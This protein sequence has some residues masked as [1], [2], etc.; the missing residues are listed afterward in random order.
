M[1][2]RRLSLRP[3]AAILATLTALGLTLPARA[4]APPADFIA[5]SA[6]A[7]NYLAARLA[8]AERDTAAAAAY[9]RELVRLFPRNGEL[10][11]RAFL[12][13]LAEGSIE[14]AVQL[15]RRI[16]RIDPEHTLARLVLGVRA[17]KAKQYVTARSN[18][19]R[20]GQGAIAELNATLLSAWSQFGSGEARA[21]VKAID[22]LQGPEW[23]TGFKDFHAG[24]ILDAAG[25][26]KESG[27]RL[28]AALKLDPRTLRV[29]DAYARWASRNADKKL[30]IET[31]E[32][33]DKLVPGDP[34]VAGALAQ[35]K[36]G[37]T[38]PPL[39]TTPAAGAAEVL[40]GIGAALGRQGGED[41]ALVYLQLGRWLDPSQPLMTITLADLFESMKRHEDAIAL[42]AAVPDSSPFKTNAEVQRA[43][44]LDAVGRHDEAL[45]VL[46][47]VVAGNVKDQRSIMA[48]GDV[49]RA[50]EKYAEA[51]EVYTRAID[52]LGTPDSKDWMLYYFRGTC[53]ERTKQWDK[54]EADLKKALAL[55]PNQPHVLNY[56]GYSW[57]DQGVNLE[58]GTDM[59]RKAVSLR[60][61]DGFFIDSLGWAY[62]RTGHY[63]E[64]VR[65]LER[66][67]ELKPN[68][69]VI[70]DH[71][72]DAYWKVDR[73]LE[74]RFKWNH[75]RDLKPEP[76]ELADIERKIAVGLDEAERVKSGKDGQSGEIQK[77]EA[78]PAAA[79]QKAAVDKSQDAPK[80]G[81]GG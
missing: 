6:P 37:K 76:D 78:S 8:I 27:Q 46:K 17:I 69:A 20:S 59:I 31:Y 39:V 3:G 18:L 14:E 43:L 64:A 30:A 57:I 77:T 81:D 44:N 73:K 72:G 35:L 42:Y 34:L 25:V 49:L 11:E 9:Y 47:Q 5:R 19:R 65:E 29:V 74:A 4:D 7:G 60:P 68:E 13:L 54:S 36:A 55:S 67:V 61:D 80:T 79:P 40:Y 22:A 51:A 33:F 66:A 45:A 50:N 15:A 32:A 21:G 75:A 16:V 41:L 23:Y 2:F 10:L 63:D 48:L 1:T 70:N 71:L 38:L 53:F 26:K 56:L 58:A 28:E 12:T 24:L 62:Y 52:D